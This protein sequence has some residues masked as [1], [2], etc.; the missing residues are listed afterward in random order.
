M[1]TIIYIKI[2]R[3]YLCTAQPAALLY[4]LLYIVVNHGLRYANP[5]HSI[6][7]QLAYLPFFLHPPPRNQNGAQRS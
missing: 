4:V 6:L 1:S 5:V 7:P 3:R 2:T